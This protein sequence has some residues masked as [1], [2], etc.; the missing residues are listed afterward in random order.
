MAPSPGTLHPLWWAST[1]SPRC[2]QASQSPTHHDPERRRHPRKGMGVVRSDGGDPCTPQQGEEPRCIDSVQVHTQVPRCIVPGQGT[3]VFSCFAVGSW[4][5]APPIARYFLSHPRRKVCLCPGGQHRSVVPIS[6]PN[7]VC[8]GSLCIHVL[9][10]G[11]NWVGY[12][13]PP[14]SRATLGGTGQAPE[15][16]VGH[17][18]ITEVQLLDVTFP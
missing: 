5:S 17:L 13:D 2:T 9:S 6:L 1:P 4:R 15:L 14:S 16:L 10:G 18:S 3:E 12:T 7:P 11:L 8:P